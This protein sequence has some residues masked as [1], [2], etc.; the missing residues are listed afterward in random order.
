MTLVL[1]KLYL[2]AKKQVLPWKSGNIHGDLMIIVD[3]AMTSIWKTLQLN[4][5]VT[6]GE[7]K[8]D[9]GITKQFLDVLTRSELATDCAHHIQRHHHRFFRQVR[10]PSH[11][12]KTALL[13]VRFRYERRS[14]LT[15]AFSHLRKSCGYAP[16]ILHNVFPRIDILEKKKRWRVETR[17]TD[18]QR[19][20]SLHCT[21]QSSIPIPN[22]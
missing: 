8:W 6:T 19:G 9:Q 5:G 15:E 10:L 1:T 21:A 17:T 3:V 4:R 7:S 22:F 11:C 14:Y 20:N 2:E 12:R 16:I 13:F 18:A